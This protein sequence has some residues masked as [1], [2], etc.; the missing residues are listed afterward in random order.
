MNPDEQKLDTKNPEAKAE[1]LSDTDLDKVAGG[2]FFDRLRARI[3]G[4]KAAEPIV[5]ILQQGNFPPTDDNDD[6]G[7]GD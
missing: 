1:E 5:S 3:E 2:A 4:R 7:D 6:D